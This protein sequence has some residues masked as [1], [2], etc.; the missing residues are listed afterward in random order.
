ME[1]FVGSN[2]FANDTVQGRPTLSVVSHMF[3]NQYE[4]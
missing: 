1:V 3:R 4:C 2:Y